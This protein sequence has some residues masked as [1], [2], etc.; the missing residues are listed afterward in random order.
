MVAYKGQGQQRSGKI[1]YFYTVDENIQDV[2]TDIIDNSDAPFE[3]QGMLSDKKGNQRTRAISVSNIEQVLAHKGKVAASAR[4]NGVKCVVRIMSRDEIVI[5]PSDSDKATSDALIGLYDNSDDYYDD[6]YDDDDD[7]ALGDRYGDDNRG[8]D[9]SPNDNYGAYDNGSESAYGDSFRRGAD[10]SGEIVGKGEW[11]ATLILMM[12]PIVNIVLLIVWLVSKKTKRSKKNFLVA[13]IITALISC[14]VVACVFIG[15]GG[16]LNGGN[17][18]VLTGNDAAEYDAIENEGGYDGMKTKIDQLSSLADAS[19]MRNG[20]ANG[21]ASQGNGNGDASQFTN[22]E[23]SSQASSSDNSSSSPSNGLTATVEQVSV[24]TTQDNRRIAIVTA[25]VK[26]AGSESG[27]S[28]SLVTVSCMQGS[29]V[30]QEDAVGQNGYVP[31]TG[32]AQIAPGG[33]GTFQKA[34]YLVDD[35]DVTVSVRGASD[36]AELAHKVQTI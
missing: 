11:V 27:S 29:N 35:Q 7:Y 21:D 8:Y 10:D 4:M 33:S 25:T 22:V 13:Y 32:D 14:A 15:I 9:K 24:A 2:A 26:N 28:N 23:D 36:G 16:S 20:N 18:R 5:I 34:Y 1:A 30:L 3:Y 31:A 12:I 6:G 17:V 19:N